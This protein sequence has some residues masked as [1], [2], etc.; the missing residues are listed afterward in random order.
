AL[1]RAQLSA[2]GSNPITWHRPCCDRRANGSLSYAAAPASTTRMTGTGSVRISRMLNIDQCLVGNARDL[3]VHQ[4]L[5]H[6]PEA[7]GRRPAGGGAQLAAVAH[8]CRA[9]LADDGGLDLDIPAPGPA[10]PRKRA[11]DELLSVVGLLCEP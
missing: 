1:R 7:H 9:R 10:G 2:F 4:E 6:L 3:G 8:E 11:S 5:D